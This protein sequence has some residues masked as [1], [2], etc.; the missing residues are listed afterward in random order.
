VFRSLPAFLFA[1]DPKYGRGEVTLIAP[2][3]R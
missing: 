2:I 3:I 1:R